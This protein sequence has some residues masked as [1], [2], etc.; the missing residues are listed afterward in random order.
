MTCLVTLQFYR[1]LAKSA[2]FVTFDERLSTLNINV[3]LAIMNETFSVIFKHG[4]H[5]TVKIILQ[6]DIFF[7]RL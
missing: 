4:V 2:I 7:A 1:L 3:T 5:M 6:E